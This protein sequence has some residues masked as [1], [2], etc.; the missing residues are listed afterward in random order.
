MSI[1]VKF[2]MFA[3]SVY[4]SW[5]FDTRTY[6]RKQDFICFVAAFVVA[7]VTWTFPLLWAYFWAMKPI[8]H[9]SALRIVRYGRDIRRSRSM[10]LFTL[11]K[12]QLTTPR[13]ADED[14][15]SF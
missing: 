11:R 7:A 9:F 2:N 8:V 14:Y 15:F 12:L 5:E 3:L 6:D 10:M 13:M 1:I 4:K